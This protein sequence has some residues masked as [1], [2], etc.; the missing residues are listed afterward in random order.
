MTTP[1]KIAVFF[2]AYCP[3][4]TTTEGRI[5]A[6]AEGIPTV[7]DALI[8]QRHG[9]P[10]REI[11]DGAQSCMLQHPSGEKNGDARSLKSTEKVPKCGS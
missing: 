7:S 6:S 11:N 10:R 1:T 3:T 5:G 4:R 2:C 8:F 9:M